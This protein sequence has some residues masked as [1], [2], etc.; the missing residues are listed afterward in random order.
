MIKV[1]LNL[2]VKN[3]KH[4]SKYSVRA[5]IFVIL[6]GL[7]GVV[8]L[9]NTS[10]QTT[11]TISASTDGTDVTSQIQSQLDSA[12]NGSTII[13]P[14]GRS[15]G[16]YRVDGRL[17]LTNR[18]NLTILGPSAS[19]PVELWTD[20]VGHDVDSKYVWVDGKSTRQN[21]R[22][23]DSSNITMRNFYIKGPNTYRDAQGYTSWTF[24]G[25]IYE[26]EH[27]IVTRGCS[28][29]TIEDSTIDSWYG[30][31]I[32]AN[33]NGGGNGVNGLVI[34]RVIAI[35]YG[36]HGFSTQNA[37]NVLVDGIKTVKGGTN[38][39][40]LEPNGAQEFIRNVEIK[41][42]IIDTRIVA[43]PFAGTQGADNVWIHDNTVEYANPSWPV[44]LV[45][46]NGPGVRRSNIKF[47]NNKVKFSTVARSVVIKHTDGI[48]VIN[49]DMPVNGRNGIDGV[50]LYDVG[51]AISVRNN[52]L[53]SAP[54]SYSR[55]DVAEAPGIDA[56]G[57]ITIAG[58]NR[59]IAC[60]P[61]D[62]TT[63]DSSQGQSA[64]SSNTQTNNDSS[65]SNNSSGSGNN[66]TTTANDQNVAQSIEH[67]ESNNNSPIKAIDNIAKKPVLNIK[68]TALRVGHLFGILFILF[69]FSGG[70]YY[71]FK[72]KNHLQ[73]HETIK[74]NLAHASKPTIIQPT[75]HI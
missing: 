28:N 45:N 35:S 5:F 38:G 49:N 8:T 10:A 55:D 6:F 4:Y 27:G 9:L 2:N 20:K 1:T 70:G 47:E 43:F 30:D 67:G 7:L 62:T 22:I 73:N 61:P 46:P 69:A 17:E 21:W 3:S 15:Q 66:Q 58:S 54:T 29:I 11:I 26:G 44:F 65:V 24:N 36:R 68:N 51:G 57:N 34:R 52:N 50:A 40:G 13:F 19:N 33:N 23:T 74:L 48:S 18:S 53:G 25:G 32:A 12:P 60:S 72:H 31:G 16:R 14:I 64:G 37:T 42:S 75:K 41:N 56:C 71:L 39:V 63:P 59:P